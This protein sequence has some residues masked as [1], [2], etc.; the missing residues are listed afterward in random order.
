[1]ASAGY[2]DRMGPQRVRARSASI[3][4]ANRP[5][6][7]S[8]SS[9][10]I[11][12]V[13]Y[14][15]RW[16][17]ALSSG[18]SFA[19]PGGG[20]SMIEN[21][22]ASIL[23]RLPVAELSNLRKVFMASPGGLSLESFVATMLKPPFLASRGAGSEHRQEKRS[24]ASPGESKQRPLSSGGSGRPRSRSVK[25][26]RRSNPR[27]SRKRG[28]ISIGRCRPRR[29]QTQR[30]APAAPGDGDETKSLWQ[31]IACSL[32]EDE[33]VAMVM[34][35]MELFH[36]VCPPPTSGAHLGEKPTKRHHACSD[37]QRRH[38]SWPSRV[39][40]VLPMTSGV[41]CLAPCFCR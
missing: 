5:S 31:G 4:H 39:I 6:L 15:R 25:G 21:T 10:L 9:Y 20:G 29:P 37:L 2:R 35:L 16:H 24:L 11:S 33:K 22:V 18:G 36:Q 28:K 12:L 30:H 7:C 17:S 8:L 3:N 40:T 34:D 38:L 41:S 19:P 26:R 13:F 1:M 32:T 23:M 14:A 27:V